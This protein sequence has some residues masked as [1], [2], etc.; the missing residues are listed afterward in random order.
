MHA[1][2]LEL[3][4]DEGG[5]V[6]QRLRA[7]G[8]RAYRIGKTWPIDIAVVRGAPSAAEREHHENL[9]KPSRTLILLTPAEV[10]HERVEAR[11]RDTVGVEHAGIDAWWDVWRRENPQPDR[12]SAR[13]ASC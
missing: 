3:L 10:C 11:G 8:L 13:W 5:D 6:R 2:T 1:A 12:R 4:Y 7:Y 9:C